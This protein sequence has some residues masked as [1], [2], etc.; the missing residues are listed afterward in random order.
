[1]LCES[2][3]HFFIAAT[4][5][6]E[7][8]CEECGAPVIAIVVVAA[9]LVVLV[10]IAV[11]QRL[12][13]RKKQKKKGDSPSVLAQLFQVVSKFQVQIKLV[14]RC[15]SNPRVHAPSPVAGGCAARAFE[16]GGRQWLL[17]LTAGG[18]VRTLPTARS[19]AS[20]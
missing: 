20:T 13:A 15:D 18:R 17:W 6:E 16:R 4:S 1:M 5:S 9:L 8:R 3:S 14:R 19:S 12:A 10:V 2:S 7:A 11:S